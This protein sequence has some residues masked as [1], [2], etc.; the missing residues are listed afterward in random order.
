M[1]IELPARLASLNLSNTH[2]YATM[3]RITRKDGTIFRF[4]DHDRDL[5]F[6]GN[7]YFAAIGFNVSAT[8]R[9]AGLQEQ[10]KEAQGLILPEGFGGVT[11]EDL[12]GGKFR[13]AEIVEYLVDW[14][15]PWAGAFYETKYLVMDMAFDGTMWRAELVGQAKY[16]RM[17]V[18][19]TYNRNCRHVFGSG[20]SD[21][22]PHDK[23][24]FSLSSGTA[25][26]GAGGA[27]VAV[28]ANFTITA[29]GN[30]RVKFNADLSAYADDAFKWGLCKFTSGNNNNLEVEVATSVGSTVTLF[31]DV[32]YD[33]EVDDTVQLTAG[34]DKT[35]ATCNTVFSNKQQYGGF[36]DIPGADRAILIPNAR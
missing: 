27:T 16:L 17:P 15:Y 11:Y 33:I 22:D 2:R 28:R 32:P 6:E 21:G 13:Q 30:A 18:G 7:D 9:Q 4:T 24:G 19:K 29:V 36:P 31:L 10:N 25:P 1:P 34:C 12:R 35:F 20:V 8:Q 14:Q 23:C 5:P 26:I 3:W